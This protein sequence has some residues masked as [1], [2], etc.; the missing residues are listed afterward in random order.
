MSADDDHIFCDDNLEA[1]AYNGPTS[2][3]DYSARGE[4]GHL[5][6]TFDAGSTVLTAIVLS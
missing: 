2:G 1:E 4:Y 3:S 5:Q 6:T